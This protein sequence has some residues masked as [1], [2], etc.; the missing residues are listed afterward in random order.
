MPCRRT[1]SA[2]FVTVSMA[3]HYSWRRV[4]KSL[5]ALLDGHL[6]RVN[7]SLSTMLGYSPNELIGTNLLDYTHPDE[8]Q[9]T[10]AMNNELAI[11]KAD[12]LSYVKRPRPFHS[13][14]PM[15]VTCS[16]MCRLARSSW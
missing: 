11:G 16:V 10:L 13:R 6:L 12:Q 15:A 4:A 3:G 14:S 7:R 9:L 1:R 2:G 5:A 8:R